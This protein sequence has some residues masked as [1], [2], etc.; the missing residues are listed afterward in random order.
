APLW[1]VSDSIAKELTLW[2]YEQIRTGIPPGEALRA[3]R[4][5]FRPESEGR[6]LSATCLAFRLYGHPKLAVHFDP[7]PLGPVR[8]VAPVTSAE[9]RRSGGPVDPAGSAGATA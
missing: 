6:P 9:S 4:T 5:R 1:S 3:M 8:T 7:R 2:F